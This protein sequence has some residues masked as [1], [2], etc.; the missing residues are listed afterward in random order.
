MSSTTLISQRPLCRK[1]ANINPNYSGKIFT[2]SFEEYLNRD[3]HQ[4][5]TVRCFCST[6]LTDN[7]VLLVLQETMSSTTL[8]SQKN[9]SPMLRSKHDRH[10]DRPPKQVHF[11]QILLSLVS[12]SCIK[13]YWHVS[14]HIWFGFGCNYSACYSH[15][16]R[17]FSGHLVTL[18]H[19]FCNFVNEHNQSQP[20]E[21]SLAHSY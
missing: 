5:N 13:E 17:L 15:I 9:P 1:G 21:T 14:G 6:R 19:M 8:I 7:Y 20:E 2:D 4:L 18:K 16:S 12:F 11:M 3:A 10:H